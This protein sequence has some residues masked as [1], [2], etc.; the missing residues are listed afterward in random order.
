MYQKTFG[1]QLAGVEPSSFRLDRHDNGF[2]ILSARSRRSPDLAAVNIDR[3][4]RG[5]FMIGA[6]STT[7]SHESIRPVRAG[8]I[9]WHVPSH[10]RSHD[11]A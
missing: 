2:T 7:L 4:S 8:P 5:T 10:R 6:L 3:P 1:G 11:S 9:E